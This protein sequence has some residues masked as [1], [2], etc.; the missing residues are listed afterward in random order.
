VTAGLLFE[1]FIAS[2]IVK[3][4]AAIRG[5][6]VRHFCLSGGKEVD[7]V[8]EAENGA[9]VG[10]DVRFKSTLS[11]R[12]FSNLRVMRDTFGKNFSRGLIIYAGT[13][14][15]EFSDGFWAIPANALWE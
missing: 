15:I 12:D 11:A 10:I 8:I 4:A 5:T 7:F 1:N 9:A 6:R 2:E 14:Q 13:E 3:Q